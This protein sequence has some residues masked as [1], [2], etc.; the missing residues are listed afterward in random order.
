MFL[1]V[2]RLGKLLV[3]SHSKDSISNLK[4]SLPSS[5]SSEYYALHTANH[6]DVHAIPYY[7]NIPTCIKVYTYYAS[8]SHLQ[9]N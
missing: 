3:V 1:L 6:C 5:V 8:C 2:V 9:R 4:G 7:H